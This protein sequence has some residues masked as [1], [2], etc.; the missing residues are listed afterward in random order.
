MQGFN[1]RTS[2]T[3]KMTTESDH[4]VDSTAALLANAD[5]GADAREQTPSPDKQAP[6]S[7]PVTVYTRAALIHLHASSLVQPPEGMPA[8]KDWYG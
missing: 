2:N 1:L 4:P 8:L 7:R 6:S 3:F 5:E